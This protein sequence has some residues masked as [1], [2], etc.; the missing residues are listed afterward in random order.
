VDKLSA[1]NAFMHA[2]QTRSFTGAGKQIGLSGSA[3]AKAIA[4]LEE[5]MSIRLFHR[6]TRSIVL[7]YEGNLLL[8]S[9]NRIMGEMEQIEARMADIGK[10]PWGRLRVSVQVPSYFVAPLLRRFMTEYPGIELDLDF[11]GDGADSVEDGFD[12]A[13]TRGVARDS[14]LISRHLGYSQRCVV[15]SPDYFARRG[16]PR[17]V[18]ELAR[19]VCLHHRMATTGTVERWP[20]D[21]DQPDAGAIPVSASAS[22]LE[23]LV[24]LVLDG[25]GI[26]C[27]PAFTIQ[28][29]LRDGTLVAV[30]DEHIAHA[31]QYVAIWPYSPHLAP[32]IRAFVDFIA[33]RMFRTESSD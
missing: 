20:L 17:G 1:L 13:I 6:S 8:E 12:V 9:C 22:T 5:S 16:I 27:I 21:I 4:R 33:P 26:A 30:L 19:H 28:R 3:V 32:K 15:G 10:R 31:E 2:A 18:G 24:H 29:Y 25:T 7:T 11:R 23:A 14:R